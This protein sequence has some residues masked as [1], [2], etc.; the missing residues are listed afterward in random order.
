MKHPPK[1][2]STPHWGVSLSVHRDDTYHKNC[3]YFLG[4]HV[5]ISEKID[6]G[7][8]CLFNGNTYARSVQSPSNDGWFAMVKK[9]HS[10]KTYGMDNKCFYGEDI[11]GIHSIEYDPVQESGTYNLFSVFDVS[12][13]DVMVCSWDDV[14]NNELG[15]PVVPT[16]HDGVFDKME[17]VTEYFMDNIS[18]PSAIGPTKEGFVMRVIDEFPLKDFSLNVCKFVRKNH[19]QTDEHWRRNWKRCQTI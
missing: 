4:K 15:F 18:T 6:G 1:Y 17:D 16:V 3:E 12:G 14:V 19:V 2:P 8:T 9:H 10:W 7:S 13:D 5:V 11:Y